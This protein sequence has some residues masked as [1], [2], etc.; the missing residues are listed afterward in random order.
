MPVCLGVPCAGVKKITHM[1][2]N[3]VTFVSPSA[4][5]PFDNP[6]LDQPFQDTLDQPFQGS[7]DQPFQDPLQGDASRMEQSPLFFTES[8]EPEEPRREPS[9]KHLTEMLTTADPAG[10]SELP[11]VTKPPSQKHLFQMGLSLVHNMFKGRAA[12]GTELLQSTLEKRPKGQRL[13]LNETMEDALRRAS[14]GTG[15]AT[16]CVNVGR[17]KDPTQQTIR[18]RVLSICVIEDTCA[19]D[20]CYD[21]DEVLD[22]IRNAPDRQSVPN[23]A[24]AENPLHMPMNLP[25][26]VVDFFE[27]YDQ[28][29]AEGRRLRRDRGANTDAYFARDLLVPTGLHDQAAS[30]PSWLAWAVRGTVRN[31]KRFIAF[32]MQKVFENPLWISIAVAAA[33][34]MRVFTCFV[35]TGQTPTEA[36]L[37]FVQTQLQRKFGPDSFVVK[38]WRALKVAMACALATITP[39]SVACVNA[40][41]RAGIPGLSDLLNTITRAISRVILEVFT[42]KRAALFFKTLLP[43]A[44][45]EYLNPIIRLA[46]YIIGTQGQVKTSYNQ[47]LAGFSVMGYEPFTFIV[48]DAKWISE[49]SL[50]DPILVLKTFFVVVVLLGMFAVSGSV[51]GAM[52]DFFQRM[53][54]VADERDAKVSRGLKPELNPCFWLYGWLSRLTTLYAG[55]SRAWVLFKELVAWCTELGPCVLRYLGSIGNPSAGPVCDCTQ[56]QVFGFESI[57]TAS[58]QVVG[59][60]LRDWYQYIIDIWPCDFRLKNIVRRDVGMMHGVPLHLYE[61]SDTPRARALWQSVGA[62]DPPGPRDRQFI[63]CSA[64][65]LAKAFPKA[66]DTLGP[67]KM[68]VVRADALPA[69]FVRHVNQLNEQLLLQQEATQALAEGKRRR[70]CR[71]G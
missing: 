9:F 40:V 16:K 17:L 48:D 32:V 30:N 14:A 18:T 36:T 57:V 45:G 66:V 56:F 54:G 65:V 44:A 37:E 71:C 62:K 22:L 25:S 28:I 26:E 38:V 41:A 69:E 13:S 27:D 34:I 11:D 42:G 64:R 23:A 52:H 24:W 5:D 51:L 50:L 10:A 1:A 35:I 70:R 20:Y 39:D 67:R 47:F 7:L 3:P 53:F 63:A 60:K 8:E 68:M 2:Q 19:V 43:T 21:V 4:K 46:D 6:F 29:E 15:L 59:Q 33:S 31:I 12:A 61:W 49:T 55:T 58:A